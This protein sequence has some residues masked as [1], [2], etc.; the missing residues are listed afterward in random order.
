VSVPPSAYRRRAQGAA[1]RAHGCSCAA[2][3][4]ILAGLRADTAGHAIQFDAPDLTAE[5][6]GWSSPP[7]ETALRSRRAARHVCRP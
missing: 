4:Q 3:Q 5:A 6:S 1:R 7:C 2:L